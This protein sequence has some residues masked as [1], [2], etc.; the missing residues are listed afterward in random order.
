MIL[1]IY[2]S[3]GDKTRKFPQRAE[4]CNALKYGP[5]PSYDRQRFCGDRMIQEGDYAFGRQL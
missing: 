1:E 4:L 5:V 3:L 2:G